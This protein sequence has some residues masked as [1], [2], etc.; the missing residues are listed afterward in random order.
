MAFLFVPLALTNLAILTELRFVSET[1][2][3]I[4][5]REP[6][7]YVYAALQYHFV[8]SSEDP[9]RN[10]HLDVEW[11]KSFFIIQFEVNSQTSH[12]HH[13]P[14]LCTSFLSFLA[15]D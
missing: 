6:C 10:T 15:I 12:F 11:N 4:I 5:A 2:S 9:V 14:F 1:E 3:Y 7:K 8:E 13:I